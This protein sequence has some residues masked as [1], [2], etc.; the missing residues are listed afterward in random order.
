MLLYLHNENCPISFKINDIIPC[1]YDDQKWFGVIVHIN[2]EN[3]DILSGQNIR[4]TPHSNLSVQHV[5]SLNRQ[6]LL[7]KSL[8]LSE[9]PI[10]AAIHLFI[11]ELKSFG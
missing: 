5:R 8:I 4:K 2:L 6:S 11:G 3:K 10:N 7:I 1:I 9:V